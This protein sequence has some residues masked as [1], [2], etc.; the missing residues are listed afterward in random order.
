MQPVL[1]FNFYDGNQFSFNNAHSTRL[2]LIIIHEHILL[3]GC[4]FYVRLYSVNCILILTH[5]QAKACES[6]SNKQVKA[7]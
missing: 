7:F 1:S 4:Y 5:M 2:L 3:P 6:I